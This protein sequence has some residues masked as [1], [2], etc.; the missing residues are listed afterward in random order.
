MELFILLGIEFIARLLIEIRERRA[1]QHRG[2]IFSILRLVPL[3]NDITPLPE[4]R[5]TPPENEFSNLHEKGHKAYRH[6][7]L[8]NI[9]KVILLMLAVWFLAKELIR[10]GLPLWEAVLWLHLVAIPFRI[11]FNLYCWNQEY[12]ADRFALKELGKTKAKAA[13]RE[14]ADYEIPYTKL[15][16][17]TY[18]EHPTVA[19]RS[20]RILH[21]T[22]SAKNKK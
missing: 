20:K 6:T 8:R 18:R 3:I 15:F 5:R 16:A 22:I 11:L 21:K 12:E 1:T 9:A 17:I 14:L 10:N 13:M 19:L 7:I 4:N 2:G